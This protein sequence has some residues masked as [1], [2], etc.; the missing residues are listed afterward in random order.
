MADESAA[1]ID[2]TTDAVKSIREAAKWVVAG[3]AGVATAIAAGSQLSS[4]GSLEIGW[5]LV[6]AVSAAVIGL[7]AV[8]VGIWR[9]ID[10]LIPT[11]AD[12]PEIANPTDS[13]TEQMRD[14]I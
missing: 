2:A 8:G 4:I 7:F 13:T 1:P 10:M 9:T 3:L 6:L 11:Q 5:R 12:L 14:Y